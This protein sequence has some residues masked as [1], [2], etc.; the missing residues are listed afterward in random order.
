MHSDRP[1]QQVFAVKIRR[2]FAG[3]LAV[4]L[5]C[6]SSVAAACDLSCGF[7]ESRADCH[8]PQGA[9]RELG[10]PDTT[11]AGMNMPEMGGDS[12]TSQ[13]VASPVSQP[14]PAHA[15]LADIGAC[16]RQPCDEVQALASKTY[17]SAVAQFEAASTGAGFP[18]LGSLRA[19]FHGI[20]GPAVHLS[21][22]I[23]SPVDVSLRI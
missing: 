3:F 22:V 1:G 14:M 10:Q 7:A 9:V 20:R 17:H 21:P 2:I 16:V 13:Q 6:G 18:Q 11:M 19:A 4:L 23:D 8:S 15:R 12:S 5:L